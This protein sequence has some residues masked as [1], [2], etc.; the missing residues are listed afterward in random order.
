MSITFSSNIVV[1]LKPGR[2]HG[3]PGGLGVH[4][5]RF[6]IDYDTPYRDETYIARNFRALVDVTVNTMKPRYLGRGWP[7]SAWSIRTG[8]FVTQQSILF[9]LDMTNDQLAIIE[10]DRNG[11]ALLFSLRIVCDLSIGD[12]VEN[13]SEEVRFT[14]NPSSWIDCMRAFGVDRTIFLELALPS[15]LTG[16]ESAGKSLE[17]ARSELDAGNYN[18]VVQQCRLAIES[19]QKAL[20]LKPAIQSALKTFAGGDRTGMSKQAR[21]LVVNEA[22][23]HYAHPAH[24]VD[25]E[26]D[27]F[28]YGRRDASFMLALASAVVANAMAE[29]E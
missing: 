19:V 5:L 21:A 28:E 15:V 6:T 24:H 13:G 1:N 22:A 14:V 7:E 2:V 26:G 10:R 4:R 12:L 3:W 25:S 27:L 20:N 17:H 8:R 23:R 9:D 11:G 29:V 16:F 18:G